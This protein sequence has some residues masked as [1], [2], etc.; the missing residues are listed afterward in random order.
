MPRHE[1]SRVDSR[2]GRR[3]GIESGN[4][5]QGIEIAGGRD[6]QERPGRDRCAGRAAASGSGG[7]GDCDR[8]RRT[9]NHW[10]GQGRRGSRRGREEREKIIDRSSGASFPSSA[11]ERMSEKLRFSWREVTDLVALRPCEAELRG[12]AFP[13]GAWERGGD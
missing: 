9:G 3:A 2:G 8:R 7:A 4:P 13:S 11:W 5:R 6:G 10:Q 12:G 1:Y